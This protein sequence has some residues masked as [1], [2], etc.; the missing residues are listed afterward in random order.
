MG[1]TTFGIDMVA[2][3]RVHNPNPIGF[4][5][6]L[7]DVTAFF[8]EYEP[9]LGGGNV[10]NVNFP[11]RSTR[12]IQFPISIAYDRHQDPGFKVIR[13]ILTRCGITGGTDNQ[14]TINYDVKATVRVIGIKISPNIKNQSYSFDCPVNIMD[15]VKE[16][17]GGISSFIGDIGAIIS[18][19]AG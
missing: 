5:F 12:H 7:I 15:I 16:I 11:S 10:T 8:P 19:V 13:Y 3:L 17:P 4:N 6:D 9:A 18:H 2:D 14:L 1:N